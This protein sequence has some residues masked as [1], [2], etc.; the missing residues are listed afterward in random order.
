[1]EKIEIE[2]GMWEMAPCA[3]YTGNIKD[4]DLEWAEKELYQI[5]I[6]A[7]AYTKQMVDDYLNGKGIL[8]DDQYERDRYLDFICE[9]EE[10][11]VI[12]IGGI[13]Y[14]DMTDEEYNEIVNKEA[15][16]VAT[17]TIKQIGEVNDELR[18]L[19]GSL[20]FDVTNENSQGRDIVIDKET[21]AKER[22]EK[23]LDY[24]EDIRQFAKVV[25]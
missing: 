3:I 21:I 6:T 8:V 14:E 12:E 2:L 4:E 24:L 1:M 20:L 25:E 23:Y 19:V 17:N 9:E 16:K 13:Y 5:A 11:L 7:H 18:D 22:L 10:K 15:T